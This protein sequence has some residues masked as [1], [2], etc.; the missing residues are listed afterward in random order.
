MSRASIYCRSGAADVS[1]YQATC[2][3]QMVEIAHHMEEIAHH[4]DGAAHNG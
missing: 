4:K 3:P 1:C 2:R